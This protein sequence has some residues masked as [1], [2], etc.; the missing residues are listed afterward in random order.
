MKKYTFIIISLLTWSIFPQER[1]QATIWTVCDQCPASSLKTVLEI[2]QSGDTIFIQGGKYYERN[3]LI[4]KPLYIQGIDFPVFDGE[5]K[6]E[7]FTIVADNVKLQGVQV[8]NVG[9]SYI[10]DRAGI[11]VRRAKHFTIRNN[12]IIN[13][14]FG[15]YLEQSRF[16]IVAENQVIGNAEDEVSSGNAIHAWYGKNITIERN[17]VQSHRDGI[18]LEFVDSSLVRMNTSEFNL[19]YGLHYMFSNDDEYHGN[20]FR[21]N[22][23]GVAV[24]FS[25]RI[26]MQ[27]NVFIKNWGKAAYGLLLKE[28]L[29]ADISNNYFIENTIAIFVEGSNRIIYSKN[30]FENNGWAIKMSGG[31]LQN[32]ISE[33]NFIANAF[34]LSLYSAVN[35]NTFNGNYWSDY[36][37]YDLDKNGVGDQPHRPVKLFNFIVNKTPEAM[38]L[39]RSLFVDLLNFSEKISPLF[40]PANVTDERP[41][42]KAF[43]IDKPETL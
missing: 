41:S 21:Q 23:A 1:L 34:D 31:C 8:E 3:I 33:N 15:I 12:R 28:I 13:S 43:K 27:D 30:Q 29:D 4:E 22:G 17:L 25:R 9:T 24:M 19:R 35:D 18:Y 38:I 36:T 40:T 6:G 32:K 20:T 10:E 2:A 16:G 37:G 42:M 39:H 7:V 26:K 5:N 14:F 11:R